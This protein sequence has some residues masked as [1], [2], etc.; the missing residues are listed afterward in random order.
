[1]GVRSVQ[2]VR[3]A[4]EMERAETE[5]VPCISGLGQARPSLS[6]AWDRLRTS[7]GTGLRPDLA[8]GQKSSL[9]I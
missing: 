6:E 5:S 7:L 9:V 1:M 2:R 4:A 3:P 8:T